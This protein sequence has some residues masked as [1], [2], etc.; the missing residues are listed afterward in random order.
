M[1]KVLILIGILF[2]SSLTLTMAQNPITDVNFDAT[3]PAPS[4]TIKIGEVLLI[5][6][7]FDRTVYVSG[8]PILYLNTTNPGIYAAYS[9][10]SGSTTLTFRYMVQSGDYSAILDY[11][12]TNSLNPNGG[13]IT[14][15]G[16]I[17]VDLT[18]PA[19]GTLPGYI[20]L[21]VDAQSPSVSSVTSSTV[22]GIYSA[23]TATN[24]ISIQVNFSENVTI[25]DQGT[26]LA[27]TGAQ[28]PVL[29]LET[30][31]TDQN[32]KWVGAG[33]TDD[34]QNFTYTIVTGDTTSALNYKGTYS[35]S[36]P[37]GVTIKDAAGNNAVLTLP[38]TSDVNSLVSSGATIRD[39]EIDGI[40][41]VI[42][43]LTSSFS[44]GSYKSGDGPI[45]I[46]AT[47]SEPVST[48]G[49]VT[50]NLNSGGT[51]SY[52]GALTN[53][54]E[55][56][57]SYTIGG[58]G[59][60]AADLDAVDLDLSSGTLTDARLNPIVTTDLPTGTQSGSLARSK[61]I[62]IDNT[63][64]NLL[65]ISSTTTA[66]NYKIGDKIYITAT[67]DEVVYVTNQP[68]IK[69]NSGASAYANYSSGTGSKTLRFIYIVQES[70]TANMLDYEINTTA[71]DLNTTGTIL[72]KAG[73]G[74]SEA[75]LSPAT[76]G[77][78]GIYNT[79]TAATEIAIDGIKPQV[80]SVSGTSTYNPANAGDDV[81]I[82]VVFDQI[83]TVSATSLKLQLE[84]GRN[85]RYATYT[86][87]TGSN[88]LLFT[89]TVVAGDETNPLEVKKADSFSGGSILDTDGNTAT[90]DL[91]TTT[92]GTTLANSTILVDAITPV[93]TKITSTNSNGSYKYDA[94]TPANNDIYITVTF[95]DVV[96]VVAGATLPR[97]NLATGTAGAY[98]EY[99]NIGTGTNTLEFKYSIQ[100]TDDTGTD[101]LD[102]LPVDATDPVNPIYALS[103]GTSTIKDGNGNSVADA[104]GYIVIP[105]P[106]FSGSLGRNK[107]IILDNTA[108]KV[109][110][111]TTVGVVDGITCSSANAT[112]K[113]GDRIYIK[114]QFDENVFVTGKPR[115]QLNS[116]TAASTAYA[117][118]YSGS[119][120]NILTFLY[121]VQEGEEQTTALDIDPTATNID[122]NSGDITDKAKNS[123]NIALPV[124]GTDVTIVNSSTI[125]IDGI[126]PSY[127]SIVGATS[128]AST[129]VNKDDVVT[130]TLT[131][132]ENVQVTG[133]PRILLETGRRDKYAIYNGNA[134]G[135]GTTVEF[136][137][138]V[139]EGDE[140][141][142]LDLKR[143][144]ISA[145]YVQD[146]NGNN[147]LSSLGTY[148]SGDLKT[149]GASTI[150]VDAIQ[151]T[152]V[153][154]TSSSSNGYYKQGENIT[155]QVVF[156]ENLTNT[157]DLSGVTLL[158]NTGVTLTGASL[159]GLN[160]KILEFTYTV[161]ANEENSDLN[162]TTVN[163]L[164]DGA[165][166]I[167]DE[168]GNTAIITLPPLTS[169]GSL[170]R[171][172]NIYVDSKVPG[173]TPTISSANV[174]GNYYVNQNIFIKLTFSENVK[175]KGRPY[176]TLNSNGTVPAVA[177][178]YSGSGSDVLQFKYTIETD[179][180]TAAT[181]L[182]VSGANSLIVDNASGV[183]ISDYAGN[184]PASY[185]LSTT[186]LS[187]L[188]FTI[189]NSA[190][191]KSAE[192]SITDI[193][194]NEA[195]HNLNMSVY[196]N[197]VTGDEITLYFNPEWANNSAEIRVFS[198]QGRI[199]ASQ[200]L[201]LSDKV[202]IDQKLEPG[203]YI[204]NLL[205]DNQSFNKRVVVE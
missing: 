50:L 44:N 22:D 176:I 189:N 62:V 144:V 28:V 186:E 136:E 164:T 113:I 39:I 155:I 6:V 112:Y 49:T 29:N 129:T 26:G 64:V 203:T 7:V 142:A 148:T 100:N 54:N 169:S 4:G 76:P 167:Q 48:T 33:A 61:N 70:D 123:I 1:K 132:D 150:L 97:L 31:S 122:L 81:T 74:F 124:P 190:S 11:V 204:L 180:Y 200:K 69:M 14:E 88:S 201:I 38:A 125:K 20:S 160:P 197:P 24:T 15:T 12:A 17:D 146:V 153:K 154:V 71:I 65:S 59:E 68:R 47:F 86:S 58:A 19:T 107:N 21:E 57:F 187:G 5:N 51:A 149:S 101:D 198:L 127:Q 182:N 115:I 179:N 175:V 171:N 55:V 10:G 159:N 120:R 53:Q 98:A 77:T 133:T 56:T 152:V 103:I 40:T 109:D 30:G 93:V 158:L 196:P 8:N 168:N 106:G 2:L 60:D 18:L 99:D 34:I 102:Y 165:L 85:D 185:T 147:A 104:N 66:G 89:Y 141:A 151:P 138:T 170:A 79:S 162:Y 194:D 73:N 83:V 105:E 90:I 184:Y 95:D 52:T 80:K 16:G 126:R 72:D 188:S 32:A 193:K 9:S 42:T 75:S 114:V 110:D 37:S 23:N 131:Y 94:V 92:S 174:A 205:K 78:D 173:V 46:T 67:F 27:P 25:I 41:P 178:Y 134:N 45:E 130:I 117:Y 157:T 36:L 202:V 121:K 63:T 183:Y 161:G 119:G 118:Y 135:T 192:L 128:N 13:S 82:K 137:Y 156:S 108:P 195:Q 166:S 140:T 96:N 3:V 172:K 139:E 116:T 43:N 181:T 111:P 199:V 191:K 143:T 163:D 87:G 84:T 91:L 35:L 177:Y 145:G